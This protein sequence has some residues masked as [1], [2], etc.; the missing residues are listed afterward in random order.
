[1]QSLLHNLCGTAMSTC[2]AAE[3][4]SF[5]HDNIMNVVIAEFQ[6][7][8]IN[9]IPMNYLSMAWNCC[10]SVLIN[11]CWVNKCIYAWLIYYIFV[12][13]CHLWFVY[14]QCLFCFESGLNE[15]LYSCALLC[16]A[17]SLLV[18]C[19]HHKWSVLIE[20]ELTVSWWA[21]KT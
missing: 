6:C 18:P 2:N 21:T 20:L 16:H 9:R 13:L 12:I 14:F 4:Q 7:A 1:M 10:Q 3:K 15:P 11:W 17:M 5:G 8:N 19:T